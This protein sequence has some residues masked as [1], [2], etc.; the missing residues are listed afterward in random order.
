MKAFCFTLTILCAVQSILAYPRPDFAINGVVS[1]TAQVKTAAGELNTAIGKTGEGSVTP[2]SG[3]ILL[4]TISNNLQAI[5]DAIVGSGTE[6]GNAL[7]NLAADST[8]PV[9]TVFDGVI[10]KLDAFDGVLKGTFSGKLSAIGT[11]TG[12]YIPKQFA[13]AFKTTGITL[14]ALKSALSTLK[15]DVQSAKTASGSSTSVSS[16]IIRA[17]IPAKSV[18]NVLTQIRQLKANMPLIQ[19]VIDSSLDNLNMVD[20]FIIEMKKEVDRGTGLY[21]TSIQA[22]QA[23]LGVEALN[24]GNKVSIG[25]G[26]SI[27]SLI[28]T[29]KAELDTVTKYTEDLAPKIS[30][31]DTAFTTTLATKVGAASS[32]YNT[33]STNVPTLIT[34]LVASLGQALCSPIKAVSLV[35]IA[36]GGFSD[37]C[38]SKYSPRVFAQ[39]S[40]TIDAFDVC[41]EKELSRLITLEGVVLSIAE[42]I[43]FNTADLFD[44]LSVCLDL[45]TAN[46][47]ACFTTL[48]PYYTKL[49]EKSEAH[50]TTIANLV[51]AETKASFNRLGACLFVSLS[52][53]TLSATDIASTATSCLTAGPQP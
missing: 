13:D 28:S 23:N 46:Q 52:S 10:A 39:V 47:G 6:L 18:N 4:T 48:T 45:P 50:L 36:N 8:G 44:N 11:D 9:A 19:F 34:D 20:T 30:A 53:T 51:T 49:A 25:I 40:L 17:K 43:A 29:I 21:T 1:G 3:Y 41:F 14:A 16:A 7:N 12:V 37:F 15:A 42:Q 35:Q 32:A 2:T 5:G 27:T 22:F 33:Y 26:S 31:L 24:V 38:F